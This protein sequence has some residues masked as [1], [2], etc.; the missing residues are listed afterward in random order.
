MSSPPAGWYPDP[1]HPTRWRWWD[2]AGWGARHDPA[3]EPLRRQQETARWLRIAVWAQ[4]IVTLSGIAAVYNVVD[5]VRDVDLDQP[6][7]AQLRLSP[8]TSLVSPLGMGLSIC[9]ILWI[10]R[11]VETGVALGRPARR[12]P[13]LAAISLMIPIVNFW[14]PVQ[15]VRDTLGDR[16]AERAAVLR[17]WIAYQAANAGGLVAFVLPFVDRRIA[18]VVATLLVAVAI[19]AAALA[20]GMTAA[21]EAAHQEIAQR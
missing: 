6:D 13:V 9:L 1:E 17:W 18:V 14:W 5:F 12:S 10:Y 3:A 15:A 2:G 11:T 21:V 19:V 16:P 20:Q 8:W 4:P 7:T